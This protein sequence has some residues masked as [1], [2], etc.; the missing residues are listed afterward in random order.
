VTAAPDP[1]GASLR[2]DNGLVPKRW[3]ALASL[4]P[5]AGDE[6]LAA[7][8]EDGVAA[9]V[10][11][12]SGSAGAGAGP[13]P[14]G[15]GPGRDLLWVDAGLRE[16]AAAV[17]LARFPQAVTLLPPSPDAVPS[18][19]GT[20]PVDDPARRPGP[21]PEHGHAERAESVAGPDG[22][23]R[24]ADRP[25]VDEDAAWA[26]I[27][28]G[29]DR[30]DAG[31]VPPWPVNED[32]GRS[33]T[34]RRA[35]AQRSAPDPL[36]ET[37]DAAPPAGPRDHSL[38]EDPADEHYVPPLPPP[39]PRLRRGTVA[40]LLVLALGVVLLFVPGA[41]G[42]PGSDG[43]AITGIACIVGSVAALVHG[44]RDAGRGGADS[45]DDGAVV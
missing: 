14:V 2:R 8:A 7:L 32:L 36:G 15:V 17:L 23:R 13:R 34:A 38:A 1:G 39:L 29:W 30:E 21:P 35:D 4:D 9:L 27:V 33:G 25:P 12:G 44:M 45:G 42:F 6:V 40:A 16:Q 18:P 37:E 31:P 24:S 41:L 43:V 5:A 10:E 26:Q 22:R 3:S 28:A 20:R 19:P 11:S